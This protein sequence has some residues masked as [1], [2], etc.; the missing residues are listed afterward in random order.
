MMERWKGAETCTA[1]EAT[2]GDR[3]LF[4]R[5]EEAVEAEGDDQTHLL[6]S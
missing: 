4:Q 2:W 5:Q 1:W 3:V 6:N